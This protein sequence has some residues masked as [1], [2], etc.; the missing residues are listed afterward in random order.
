MSDL[1]LPVLHEESLPMLTALASVLG[2]PRDALASDDQV[3]GAWAGLPRVLAKI[4]P[5]LRTEQHVRMCVAVA[6]GLFDAAVNYAWNSAVVELRRKVRDFGVHVVPQ[7]TQKPFDEKVLDEMKD[8][9]LL[10]LCLALNLIDEDGFFFLDQCRN[11]R[12][13]FSSAHPPMGNL[14][15]YEFLSFL[16]RCAKYA[17]SSTTNPRGVDI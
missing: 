8:S 7:I 15:E 5:E 9:D 2:V 4:P 10:S 3:R 6:A 12:N 14:D 1:N 13:N 17:L 11:I 16:N